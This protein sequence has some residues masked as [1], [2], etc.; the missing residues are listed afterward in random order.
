MNFPLKTYKKGLKF[1]YYVLTESEVITDKSQTMRGLDVRHQGR[2]LS[3]PCN[4]LTD[5][6]NKLFVKW[7]FHYGPELAQDQL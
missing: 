7:L 4:D 6:V 5:E 3:F 1:T 2:G